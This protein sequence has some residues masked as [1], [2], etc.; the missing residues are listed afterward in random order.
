MKYKRIERNIDNS[1]H[2]DQRLLVKCTFFMN[3]SVNKRGCTCAVLILFPI[4]D[5]FVIAGLS[6]QAGSA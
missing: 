6:A 2:A 3:A 5:A 4:T 1:V